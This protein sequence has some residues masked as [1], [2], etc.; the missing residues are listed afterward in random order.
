MYK[1]VR[2]IKLIKMF[3][4][5]FPSAARWL[6]CRCDRTG[7]VVCEILA[8]TITRAVNTLWQ[9]ETNEDNKRPKE[10]KNNN[11]QTNKNRKT[12]KKKWTN[13]K[14][15]T[16]FGSFRHDCHFWWW[17]ERSGHSF[18]ISHPSAGEVVSHDGKTTSST[19]AVGWIYY[20]KRNSGCWDRITTHSGG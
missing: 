6:E 19:L 1:S 18:P 13:K 15:A 2:K 12:T 17:C 8:R 4:R 9:S 10:P 14:S 5:S 11:T 20:N 3:R 16:P 7:C